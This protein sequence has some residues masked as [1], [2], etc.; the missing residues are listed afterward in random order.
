MHLALSSHWVVL[1]ALFLYV[2]RAPPQ[3]LDVAAR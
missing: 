1:A 3:P 2:R